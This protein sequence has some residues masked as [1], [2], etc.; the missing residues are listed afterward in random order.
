MKKSNSSISTNIFGLG[1]RSPHYSY[2]E[3]RPSTT[4]GWFEV[5][6]ENY[7]RTRGRPR[8]IL[9][10]LRADYPISCHGVSLSIASYEDFDWKYL[11]DLKKFYNEIQPFQVSDHLCFTGLKNNNL[12]NLL[13]VAFT[14]ENL[15]H[16]SE[17]IDIVQNYLGRKLAFE[18]L[19]A[20]FD[21][22][23]STLSEWEFISELAKITD[24]DLLLDLNNIFVNSYNHQF[25]PDEFINAI[26]IDRVKEIHL[27][28][29]SERDGFYF[30]T[31]SNPLY[32]ELLDL[33]KK[34]LSRKKDIPTL[35]EWDEDIPSFEILETQI[36]ELRTIWKNYP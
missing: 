25:N 20:Y 10:A 31:H 28:G 13:P 5:I 24:C 32:P 14:R 9:D 19:S 12:H 8:R 22:K 33:Y 29:F 30:D 23:H 15:I 4:A 26:P 7:F 35:F 27:A 6:S 2:L 17:R 36:I 21:Y 3:A 11:E 16:L 34:V 18:N 1:L